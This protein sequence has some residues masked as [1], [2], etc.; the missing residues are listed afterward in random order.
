VATF[1][2]EGEN[3]LLRLAAGLAAPEHVIAKVRAVLAN[4]RP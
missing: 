3:M 1:G 2:L 4:F